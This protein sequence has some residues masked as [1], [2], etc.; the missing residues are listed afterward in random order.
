MMLECLP[1]AR[2]SVSC[3]HVCFWAHYSVSSLCRTAEWTPN[4]RT[5]CRVHLREERRRR[6]MCNKKIINISCKFIENLGL[7]IIIVDM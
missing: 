4:E 3:R 7:L 5:V 6:I 2:S 1:Q